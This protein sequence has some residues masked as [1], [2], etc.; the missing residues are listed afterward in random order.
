M[1]EWQ[2][3]N[4]VSLILE[5]LA[6]IPEP[7]PTYLAFISFTYTRHRV[8]M[9]DYGARESQLIRVI[10]INPEGWPHPMKGWDCF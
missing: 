9:Q 6:T 1:P 4:P 10:G 2:D 7:L 8:L 5:A 3:L